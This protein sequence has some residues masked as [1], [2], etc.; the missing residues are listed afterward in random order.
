[1]EEQY[2][3]AIDSRRPHRELGR[4]QH[5]AA[6]VIATHRSASPKVD[7]DM[8]LNWLRFENYKGLP[9]RWIRGQG[10]LDL[11]IANG[12]TETSDPTMLGESVC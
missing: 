2:R 9:R 10:K 5:A 12:M 4:D 11:L 7:T 8:R 3:R 6:P 1:M